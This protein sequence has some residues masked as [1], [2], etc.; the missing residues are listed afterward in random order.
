[1]AKAPIRKQK[2]TG[3]NLFLAVGLSIALACLI[4]PVLLTNIGH[5]RNAVSLSTSEVV[6]QSVVQLNTSPSSSARGEAARWLGTQFSSDSTVLTTLSTSLQNDPDPVVRATVANTIAQM[7]RNARANPDAAKQF[8]SEEERIASLLV[9][10]YNSEKSEAVRRCLI[11]AAG[12][13]DG[14]EAGK[15][16]ENALAD[17]DPSVK[18]EALRAKV[19][20][21]R[22]AQ[23][24]R[25]G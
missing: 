17:N 8:E 22:R 9:E 3:L 21:E 25:M 10:R 5:G 18:E 12:E 2:Q 6:Q 23:L 16:I 7:A 4:V 20:R 13:L 15:L 11:S 14:P 24:K 1:M 19:E